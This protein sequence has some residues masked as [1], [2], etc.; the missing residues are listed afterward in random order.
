MKDLEEL[1]ILLCS[2]ENYIGRLLLPKFLDLRTSNSFLINW[3][4]IE[5]EGF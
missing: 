1:Y 2:A 3:Y 4:N 5:N